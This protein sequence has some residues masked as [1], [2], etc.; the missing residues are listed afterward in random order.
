MRMPK[1]K[2]ATVL[3]NGVVVMTEAGSAQEHSMDFARLREGALHTGK[4][5]EC[6]KFDT[7]EQA[8]AH[9]ETQG[10]IIV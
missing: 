1:Y 4:V 9:C 8:K 7:F 6:G 5:M 2:F 10:Y 3:A